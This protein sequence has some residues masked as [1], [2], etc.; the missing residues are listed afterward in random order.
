MNR[1]QPPDSRLLKI[2]WGAIAAG[3]GTKVGL[4]IF[5]K[6]DTLSDKVG[7]SFVELIL[8]YCYGAFGSDFPFVWLGASVAGASFALAV[9]SRGT[10][11]ATIAKRSL[12][13]LLLLSLF[14][15]WVEPFVSVSAAVGSA[16]MAIAKVPMKFAD[17]GVSIFWVV[18][19]WRAMKEIDE[20]VGGRGANASNERQGIVTPESDHPVRGNR[21]GTPRQSDGGVIVVRRPTSINQAS[22]GV[23]V[24]LDGQR[25]GKIR[26]GGSITL[27]VPAG[28]HRLTVKYFW[29][30]RTL[31]VQVR[32]EEEVL[33]E[34]TFGVLIA[35]P[36]L[37]RSR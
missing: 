23:T 32:P 19:L 25:V 34:Q 29:F 17:I 33:I 21:T 10:I 30:T 3:F 36:K 14:T 5:Q 9:C 37:R 35:T 31:E 7:N 20:K 4:L 12:T 22:Y 18:I 27:P 15:I 2:L 28:K 6:R 11:A 26:N 24:L 1:L 8:P 13:V 16:L